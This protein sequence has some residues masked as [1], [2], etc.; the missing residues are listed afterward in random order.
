MERGSFI[1][2]KNKWIAQILS[3]DYLVG[4]REANYVG[5]KICKTHIEYKYISVCESILAI[6]FVAFMYYIRLALFLWKI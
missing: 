6:T 3:F 1:L 2:V 4:T 5:K